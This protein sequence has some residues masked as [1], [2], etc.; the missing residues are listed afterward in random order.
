MSAKDELLESQF[1]EVMEDACEEGTKGY[2]LKAIGL[3]HHIKIFS[4]KGIPGGNAT[5]AQISSAKWDTRMRILCQRIVGD[6]GEDQVYKIFHGEEFL[7]DE[8]SDFKGFLCRDS[9]KNSIETTEE[10]I[11][12]LTQEAEVFQTKEKARKEAEEKAKKAKKKKKKK[13]KKKKKKITL[14]L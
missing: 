11:Q 10:R 3:T 6:L 12:Q 2:G 14:E 5:G 13:R 9:C 8:N 4:G 7:Q 1:I